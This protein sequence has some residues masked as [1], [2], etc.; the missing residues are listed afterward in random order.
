MTCAWR[1]IEDRLAFDPGFLDDLRVA[2]RQA[3]RTLRE[4]TNRERE[5]LLADH[6][7]ALA[8]VLEARHSA[9]PAHAPFTPA[10][11]IATSTEIR[12]DSPSVP[13]HVREQS[14]NGASSVVGQSP[15]DG[16][17]AAGVQPR[18]LSGGGGG[19][20]SPATPPVWRSPWNP[21][22]PVFQLWQGS[23]FQHGQYILGWDA[24][25]PWGSPSAQPFLWAWGETEKAFAGPP[26]GELD[27]IAAYFYDPAPGPRPFEAQLFVRDPE[28]AAHELEKLTNPADVLKELVPAWSSGVYEDRYPRAEV[29]TSQDPLYWLPL[30]KK[31]FAASPRTLAGRAADPSGRSSV[32]AARV[33][34]PGLYAVL[35]PYAGYT[36]TLRDQLLGSFTNPSGAEKDVCN[37]GGMVGI[38]EIRVDYLTAASILR[39]ARNDVSDSRGGFV[40]NVEGFV[41]QG[42]YWGQCVVQMTQI[43]EWQLADGF[44]TLVATPLLQ[45]VSW[46]D[47]ICNNHWV[48]V[49]WPWLWT[50][51]YGARDQVKFALW[52]DVPTAVNRTV[53]EKQ[54]L[55]P[56]ALTTDPVRLAFSN[57]WCDPH[58]SPSSTQAAGTPFDPCG[59]ARRTMEHQLSVAYPTL[60]QMQRDRL[61]AQGS[62]INELDQ[63]GYRNW[64][65]IPVDEPDKDQDP[66]GN[67]QWQ[68]KPG[69][70]QYALRAKRL[71]PQPD[72][73]EV[74]FLDSEWDF[75]N[76]PTLALKLWLE[77]FGPDAAA[78]MSRFKS[79]C[80]AGQSP[81]GDCLAYPTPIVFA[82]P[83]FVF[84]EGSPV[85]FAGCID[86]N[87][88]QYR[89]AGFTPCI[90]NQDGTITAD[91]SEYPDLQTWQACMHVGHCCRGYGWPGLYTHPWTW[92]D[93]L[94]CFPQGA[95]P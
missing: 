92:Q 26:Y 62:G 45:P 70:C 85:G 2:P 84:H 77:S 60:P 75:D 82:R 41:R 90:T 73:L 19:G 50:V 66:D 71:V 67:R 79:T 61:Y 11:A 59:D 22:Q 28:D 20:G 16:Q 18:P 54:W 53:Y 14:A 81:P 12:P 1:A 8:D 55:D 47:P 58:A 57:W 32:K 86:K 39:H 43:Y 91:P 37:R 23:P 87:K 17:A 89:V 88:C 21:Y 13:L 68:D 40:L 63:S 27:T 76:P 74:V 34:R 5:D 65:C 31:L 15:D 48:P 94:S 93:F 46:G 3:L 78:V 51:L 42:M 95:L 35:L 69:H 10:P 49:V 56:L 33:V 64:R 24:G 29:M 36:A 30:D 9:R 72:E 83:F 4:L 44:V 6:G 80:Q 7:R 38:E 25:L 52:Q